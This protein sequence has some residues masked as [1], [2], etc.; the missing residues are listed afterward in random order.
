MLTELTIPKKQ[1]KVA[2]LDYR[3][4]F[5][6]GLK[7]VQQLASRIWTDYNVHDPGIT[8]LELLCYA[9]TDLGYR[10]SFPVKDLFATA[11]DNAANM[12][13]SFFTARKILT[14]RPL[15]HADYRK[16]LIDLPGIKNAWFEPVEKHF[17]ADTIKGELLR[18]KPDLDGIEEVSIAGLYKVLLDY[19]NTVDTTAKKTELLALA[20]KTVMANRN[21]CE[22]FVNFSGV[23]TQ[24]FVLCCELEIAPDADASKVKAALYYSIQQYLA[25]SVKFYTLSQMLEKEKPGGMKYTPEDIFNGPALDNGFID[26]TELSN[27]S[28]RSEI[29]LSDIISIIMDIE[30]VVAVHNIVIG[31][32]PDDPEEPFVPVENKW[33]VEVQ[34]GKKALLSEDFLSEANTGIK[35]YK[36][37]MPVVADFTQVWNELLKL[38][39]AEN[40]AIPAGTL[41]DFPIP[42]GNF[43]N[44]SSYHS[45]QN[46]YPAVY[47]IGE[48]GLEANAGDLRKAKAYQLKAYLLF[49]DQVMANFFSQLENVRQLFSMDP[50][51]KQTYFH[52]VVKSFT[53]YDKIYAGSNF[54]QNITSSA[55][56]TNIQLERRN[57]FL[58]HMIARFA[59]QFTEFANTMYSAFGSDPETLIQIK[60]DF[61]QQYSEISSERLLAYNYSLKDEASLW[62]SFNVSGFERRI[63]KL[64]G[65]TNYTRR[66]LANLPYELYSELDKTPGDEFRFRIKNKDTAKI[67]LSSSA[68]YLTHELAWAEMKNTIHYA[69]FQSGYQRKITTPTGTEQVKHYFNIVN[70]SG[71]VIAR[72]IEYFLSETLMNKAIDDIMT[73]LQENFNSEGMFLIENLMLLPVEKEDPFL[74]ICKATEL[75]TCSGYDP[76]SYKV[77]I[78]LPAFAGRFRNMDFRNFAEQLILEETPA[79]ILPKICWISF[80]DMAVLEK[81]YQEWISLKAGADTADRTT[82]LQEFIKALFEVKNT[83]PTQSLFECDS[84]QPK[85]ILGQT[86]LGSIEKK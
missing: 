29:R 79:H 33:I 47:G 12:A 4:L 64:L 14:N 51:V 21:L 48:A 78:I 41:H 37:N 25:P 28:L 46:H 15:T 13:A 31:P 43:K 80:E 3:Q 77:H 76:Y 38:Y 35:F 23:E 49:F 26:N 56:G 81:H 36:R 53:E 8:T 55:E 84:E 60:C 74:P 17:Y 62:N 16:L 65:I 18:E 68:H 5:A 59:E 45:F 50:D 22:D 44:T 54:L 2:A 10:A 42:L 11:D 73:Y 83:Y 52:Q 63:A 72:R 70:P 32:K 34:P 24:Y 1:K 20:E 58:D 27:A 9:L 86:T 67:L 30:G 66:N 6:E 39:N 57:R 82:K 40:Y 69:S 75:E 61:L 71:E 19:D 85:F 7:H